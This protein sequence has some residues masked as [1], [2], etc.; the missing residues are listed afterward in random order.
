M[1][2]VATNER[3]Y[4]AGG[5]VFVTADSGKRR[6]VMNGYSLSLGGRE[7]DPID[8][9]SLAL[10]LSLSYSRR[11]PAHGDDKTSNI[12]NCGFYCPKSCSQFFVRAPAR[13]WTGLL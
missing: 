4:R 9:L 5:D 12:I 13:R 6:A 3:A 1:E 2:V 7:R 11:I 10:S 8:P